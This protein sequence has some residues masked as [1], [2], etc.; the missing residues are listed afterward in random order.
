MYTKRRSPNDRVYSKEYVQ[1]LEEQQIA[2]VKG[3]KELYRRSSQGETLP[4]LPSGFRDNMLIHE[5]LSSLDVL[6]EKAKRHHFDHDHDQMSSTAQ[7]SRASSVCEAMPPQSYFLD[8]HTPTSCISRTT[9]SVSPSPRMPPIDD[10]EGLLNS[11][12]DDQLQLMQN[13]PLVTPKAVEY[14][15][16]EVFTEAY[17]TSRGFSVGPQAEFVDPRDTLRSMPFHMMHAY[18]M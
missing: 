15:S 6:P 7:S 4:D 3:V 9:S 13:L 14:P 5:V 2:L 12:D 10:F 8:I 1:L 11:L 18:T 16:F 17:L